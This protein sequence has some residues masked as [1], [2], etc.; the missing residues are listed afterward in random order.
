MIEPSADS[1][2]PSARVDN[3]IA[4]ACLDRR[5]R[6]PAAILASLGLA[7]AG[8]AVVESNHWLDDEVF[9]GATFSG[10]NAP[11]RPVVWINATNLNQRLPFADGQ[12]ARR[13]GWRCDDVQISVSRISFDDLVPPRAFRLHQISTSL[14]LSQQDVDTVIEAGRDAM[15]R[16]GTVQAFSLSLRSEP[17]A[18]PLSR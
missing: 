9:H 17:D 16:N 2:A 10:M 4:P 11:G 6:R 8:C 13:A 5:R 14:T 7:L 3:P 1:P 18:A 15:V 12:R